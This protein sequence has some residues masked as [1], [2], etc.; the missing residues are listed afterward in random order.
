MVH[1]AAVWF[2]QT[3]TPS[4]QPDPPRYIDPSTIGP[5]FIGFVL[6]LLL[7]VATF[8]LWRSMNKQLKK[9]DFDEG[10]DDAAQRAGEPG[11]AGDGGT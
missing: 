1:R 11:Q 8:L 10:P 3:T 9:I 7:A 5:G 4:P 6:F 2:S